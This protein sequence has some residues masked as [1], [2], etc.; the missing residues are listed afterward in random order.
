[1][2]QTGK[3]PSRGDR[4]LQSLDG[5]AAAQSAVQLPPDHLPRITIQNHSQVDELS[6]QPDV[7][8]IGHPE[9]ID[10]GQLHAP[11]QIQ[12]DL[13]RVLGIRGRYELP[14]LHRQQVILPH[15]SR[16]PLVVYPH[17]TALQLGGNASIAI[18][19][20]MSQCDCLDGRSHLRVFF[21]WPLLPQRPVEAGTAHLRQVTHVLDTQTA[22]HRH[23]LLDLVVD[24]VPPESLPLWRRASIFCK[25]PLKKSTSR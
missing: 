6:L 11:R 10:S 2:H 1:M 20:T 7:S 15:D 24:A 3:R 12:I 21:L 16:Y 18:A 4:S 25:A 14:R 8:D 9:L 17:P 13:Q 22:L 23:Q 19:A 5:Q